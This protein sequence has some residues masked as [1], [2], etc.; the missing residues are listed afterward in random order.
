MALTLRPE[1]VLEPHPE[2]GL[3]R[4][5]RPQSTGGRP[6][7][8]VFELHPV[9]GM[10]L[11]MLDGRRGAEEVA[12]VISESCNAT[13]R[14]VLKAVNAVT[15]RFR[16]L[17]V[18][19]SGI[20]AEAG[21]PVLRPEDFDFETSIDLRVRREAAPVA[22]MWVVTESCNRRCRYCFRDSGPD[23]I[24]TE[25]VQA[26]TLE[27]FDEL[28]AEAARIGVVNLVL[29]GGE[30]VLRPDLFDIIELFT[31]RGVEVLLTTKARIEAEAMRQLAR[32]PLS[33]LHLSLDSADPSIVDFLTDTPG[34][35]ADITTTLRLA[36][37]HGVRVVLRPV[38]TAMS[39]KG[40]P[41]LV[42]FASE[43]G[44][45]EIVVDLY[46]ESCGRHDER[47]LLTRAEGAWLD[48]TVAEV[49]QQRPEVAISYRTQAAMN[50]RPS[51]RGCVE[52]ARGLTFMPDGTVT[53]CEHWTA[54][55]ALVYGD[56]RVQSIMQ[57]WTSDAL[58]RI[59]RPPQELFQGTACFDCAELERCIFHRGRCLVSCLEGYGSLYA[60][61]SYCPIGAHER[62]G[63]SRRRFRSAD[64]RSQ[65]EQA[66]QGR[67]IGCDGG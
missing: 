65:A 9:Q 44:V 62:K 6:E 56:L 59:N 34:A 7:D 60:P 12:R 28:S 11:G 46:G 53:R 19:A 33:V 51:E 25:A 3:V 23:S 18:E 32:S 13:P 52:G 29:T 24:A 36:A 27:R 31:S 26:L 41:E 57:A 55:D 40:F 48:R 64:E 47:F 16:Q 10:I 2:E 58:R 67:S 66:G 61:D 8:P 21:R 15:G 35:F 45:R 54:S 20:N 50:A 38:M 43:H 22:L 37:E 1:M 17:L 39:Y 4:L 63:P 42:S 5:Y 14:A 30:P 49:A